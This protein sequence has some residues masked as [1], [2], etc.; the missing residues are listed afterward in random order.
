MF[1]NK[2]I[3]LG[4]L[5][6]ISLASLCLSLFLGN[7]EIS[8]YSFFNSLFNDESSVITEIIVNI[9]LPRTLSA[10]ITGGLLAL[11]GSFMQVLLRNPLADPYILGVSGGAAIFALL[12]MLIGS[13]GYWITSSA[14]IGGLLTTYIIFLMTQSITGWKKDKLLLTGIALASGFSA[15][16]SF[17]L[18]LTPDRNLHGMLFWLSGDLSFA[19]WPLGE[20][21]ILILIFFYSLTLG[22]RKWG[23]K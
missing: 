19:H 20:A 6:T 17:I 15:I 21:I 8:T 16:I 13:T 12:A 3:Y 2:F 7:S 14:A 9:R 10:F 4:F 1:F 5:L 22:G 23:Q 11:A 18:I